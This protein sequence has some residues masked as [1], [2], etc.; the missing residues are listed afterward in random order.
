MRYL[1]SARELGDVLILG[2][3]DDES[4]RRLK[5]PERPFNILGDRSE[6]LAGLEFVDLVVAF[7][8]DTPESLIQKI[9]PD[10]LVKGSDWSEQV[11][12]GAKFVEKKGGE[13]HFIELLPGRSTTEIAGRIRGS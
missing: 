6:V 3:N 9:S 7:S 8:E 12:A 11:V 1:R 4:V 10:V 5:G 13:V 2:L